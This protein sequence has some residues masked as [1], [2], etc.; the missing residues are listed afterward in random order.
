MDGATKMDCLTRL[1]GSA[2]IAVL[3]ARGLL[4]QSDVGQFDPTMRADAHP[5]AGAAVV[6]STGAGGQF[7]MILGA[8]SPTFDEPSRM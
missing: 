3:G 1:Q 6:G 8:A 4:A 2:A 7:A 5:I